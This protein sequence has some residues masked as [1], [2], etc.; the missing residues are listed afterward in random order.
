M[1]KAIQDNA[2]AAINGDKDVDQAI[3][4]MEAALEQAGR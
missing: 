1:S 2:Y 4:D 3:N